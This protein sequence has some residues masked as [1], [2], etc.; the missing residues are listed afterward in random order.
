MMTDFAHSV[1]GKIAVTA[2]RSAVQPGLK[3]TQQTTWEP[4]RNTA[5]TLTIIPRQ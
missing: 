4:Q 3:I 2:R 5:E 1:S